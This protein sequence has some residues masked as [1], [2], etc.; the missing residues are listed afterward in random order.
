MLVLFLVLVLVLVLA[1]FLM[2]SGAVVNSNVLGSRSF[3]SLSRFF[4]LQL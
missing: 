2:P 3:D 4:S 1:L